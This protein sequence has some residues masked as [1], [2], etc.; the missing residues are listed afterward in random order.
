[1]SSTYVPVVVDLVLRVLGRQEVGERHGG[2]VEGAD[3]VPPR[4][5][6]LGGEYLGAA[7]V[8]DVDQRD[9]PRRLL[10]E[11]QSV[12]HVVVA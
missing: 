3:D 7:H 9:R 6:L 10:D 12:D 2:G 8:L 4:R 1:M 5:G 11:F